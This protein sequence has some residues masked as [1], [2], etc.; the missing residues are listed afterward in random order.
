[1]VLKRDPLP[2]HTGRMMRHAAKNG[3]FLHYLLL[4]AAAAL[5]V[6]TLLTNSYFH[7]VLCVD[8]A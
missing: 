4:H 7:H 8:G 6:N 2:I 1:M 3:Y 5:C